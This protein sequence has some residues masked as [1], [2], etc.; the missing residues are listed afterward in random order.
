M[1]HMNRDTWKEQHSRWGYTSCPKS[2]SG[3]GRQTGAIVMASVG[4]VSR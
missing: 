4:F 3:P 2:A 1:T